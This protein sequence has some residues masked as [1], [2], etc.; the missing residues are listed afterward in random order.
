[1]ETAFLEW[2]RTQLPDE[3]ADQLGLRDDAAVLSTAGAA[4]LVAA[5]DTLTDGVDFLLEECDPRRVGRKSL[6]VN[7]S[8]M[9]AMAAEPVAA[10][11]SLVLPRVPTVHGN[12][13][14][15]AK[16]LCEG[17]LPLARRFNVSIAGGDTNTWSGGLV[18]GITILGR[19]SN[20]QVLTRGGA[21]PGDAILVTGSFGGSILGRHFDFEPRVTEALVL[22]ERFELHAGT[23]VSDSLSID[24][25]HIAATS[26]CGVELH[27]AAIP[28]ADDAHRRAAATGKSALEHALTDGEDFELI[29]A[30]PPREAERMV[31]E[32][33]LS[34]P[35]TNI[36]QFIKSPR[37]W[38]HHADGARSPLEPRG[39]EH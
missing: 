23:D 9:A 21:R 24:L 17:L 22:N 25:A 26:G 6:A 4:N 28:V 32:Q 5:H 7:L 19:E 11:V 14:E 37:L 34:T 12:A 15:L 20:G 8:D 3:S 1:M 27:A 31:K 10:L 2:L 29:L 16:K 38:L 35:L 33:P 18:I 13:L 39:Y 30:V 36:G